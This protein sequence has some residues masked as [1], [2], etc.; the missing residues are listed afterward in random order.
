MGIRSPVT[1]VTDDFESLCEHWELNEGPL[2]KQKAFLISKPSLRSLFYLYLRQG[3][4]MEWRCPQT[5][6]FC[7]TLLN[8]GVTEVQD[9]FLKVLL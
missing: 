9:L 8:A 5:L 3:L 6:A 2:Q 4:T 7:R 1:G